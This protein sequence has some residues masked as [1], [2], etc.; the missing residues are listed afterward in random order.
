MTRPPTHDLDA[1]K[2]AMAVNLRRTGVA[3]SGAMAIGFGAAD[4]K[5][6]LATM[7]PSMFYKTMASE[8]K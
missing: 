4:V 8:R 2:A 6:T 5:A 3:R 1:F 7:K